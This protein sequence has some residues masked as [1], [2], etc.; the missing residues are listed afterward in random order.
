MDDWKS[1]IPMADHYKAIGETDIYLS[2]YDG[3]RFNAPWEWAVSC[4]AGSSAPKSKTRYGGTWDTIFRAI[5]AKIPVTMV[6]PDGT[7]ERRMATPARDAET[8]PTR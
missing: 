7:V 2:L 6:W 1:K 4:E 3:D 5:D 8:W